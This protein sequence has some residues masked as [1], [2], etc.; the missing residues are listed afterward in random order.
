LIL[1]CLKPIYSTTEWSS[2]SSSSGAASASSVSSGSTSLLVEKL[3]VLSCVVPSPSSIA[4]V[5]GGNDPKA[6]V[7]AEYSSLLSTTGLPKVI[8]GIAIQWN[9]S[10]ISDTIA[11]SVAGLLLQFFAINNLIRMN[12]DAL[13]AQAIKLVGAGA[14]TTTANI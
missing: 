12:V 4:G 10:S 14:G 2:S 3:V 6:V 7:A 11:D 13:L 1:N 9:A 5:R 8:T